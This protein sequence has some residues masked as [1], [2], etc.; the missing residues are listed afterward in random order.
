MSNKTSKR[1]RKNKKP[2]QKSVPVFRVRPDGSERGIIKYV[3]MVNENDKLGDEIVELDKPIHPK[4]DIYGKHTLPLKQIDSFDIMGHIYRCNIVGSHIVVSRRYPVMYLDI[5]YEKSMVSGSLFQIFFSLDMN[6]EDKKVITDNKKYVDLHFTGKWFR[7]IDCDDELIE[8]YDTLVTE[9][10]ENDAVHLFYKSDDLDI[11]NKRESFTDD[12][13][14][15]WIEE[16]IKTEKP[17]YENFIKETQVSFRTL[18]KL[19]DWFIELSQ[20]EKFNKFVQIAMKCREIHRR[21]EHGFDDESVFVVPTNV[22]KLDDVKQ[23]MIDDDELIFED[24]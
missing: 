1:N 24:N 11:I 10:L 21:K 14:T 4:Y 8:N 9:M 18:N 6:I 16:Y 7:H 12:K 2:Y 22:T 19:R 3:G 15:E 13:I 5:Y 17:F 23:K 20:S